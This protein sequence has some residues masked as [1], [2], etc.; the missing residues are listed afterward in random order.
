M[1]YILLA[2]LCKNGIDM[3]ETQEEERIE[4]NYMTLVQRF[5]DLLAKEGKNNN[6]K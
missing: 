2:N 1:S 4:P 5:V 3:E 6:D